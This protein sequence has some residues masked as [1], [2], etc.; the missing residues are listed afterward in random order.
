M[1]QVFLNE[2]S[3]HGQ[4]GD[5]SSLSD[6]VARLNKLLTAIADFPAESV[7]F[8]APSIYLRPACDARVFSS[9]LDRITEKDVRLQFKLL[10]RERLAARSWLPDRMHEA[11]PYDWSGKDVL[12]TSVAELAERILRMHR[13]C[14]LNF[15]PSEFVALD[16]ICVIKD[17]TTA[18][19]VPSL[20][21]EADVQELYAT[22]G[23]ITFTYDPSSGRPPL[24]SET[25]LRDKSRFQKTNLRNQGRIVYLDRKMQLYLCVDNLHQHGAHLEV[26]DSRGD[27]FAEST[28]D[29]NL[30]T[31]KAD[32]TKSLD[33]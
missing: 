18:I 33:L 27:H 29:G 13:G 19:E 9:C 15:S 20:C 30:D 25:V 32:G 17:G 12:G 3:L 26:F 21:N 28:L 4:F 23:L 16:A 5:P 7:I 8:F 22:H 14:L 6:A 10:L 31:A 1:M 2:L 24:D 11:C